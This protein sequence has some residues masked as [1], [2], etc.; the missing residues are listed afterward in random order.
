MILRADGVGA[1]REA[2]HA[3]DK[4]VGGLNYA[5]VR[6]PDVVFDREN[7]PLLHPLI[8]PSKIIG[9]GLNYKDH[10]EEQGVE[11]P[12]HPT[13]FAKFPSALQRP[14]GFIQWSRELTQQV[15]Y[16]AELA[17]IIGRV[18]RHVR[19][20][21]AYYYV[22]G[23]TAANDVSARDIQFGDKQWVRGKSLD[24]F[25]PLGPWVVTQDEIGDP[26]NLAIRCRVNGEIR[27]ESTTANM[28]FSVPEL[29]EFLSRSFT[30]LPG[31]IILT[32]TPAGVG[33]FRDPP[34][35]L[36]DGDR[37]EVEIE[38]IGTLTNTC[39]EL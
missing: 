26:M 13:V 25:A 6:Y 4:A 35:L 7:A 17:V 31:D 12:D 8:A 34:R 28:I 20:S 15:D 38:H 11:P 9:I 19:A 22:F 18:A 21:E 24:T 29:I 39:R 10:C 36:Q 5:H 33:I 27:Q 14:G 23:Y 32:G 1:L 2:V 30:L 37:V 16:E 3:L